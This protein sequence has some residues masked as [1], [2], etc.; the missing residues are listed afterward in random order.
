MSENL[1][2]LINQFSLVLLICENMSINEINVIKIDPL[3]VHNNIKMS[4]CDRERHKFYYN[5]TYY[6]YLC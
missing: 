4:C 5:K 3:M 6:Y 1:T 2:T